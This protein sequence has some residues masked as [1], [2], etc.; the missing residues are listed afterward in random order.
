MPEARPPEARPPEPRTPEPRTLDR[1][2]ARLARAIAPS[3]PLAPLPASPRPG[4]L[5]I[6]GTGRAGTTALM[7]LFVRLGLDT[8]FTPEDVARV[9]GNV[10]RAG[11]ERVPTRETIDA[12]PDIL[13]S[14][15]LV[16]V[17]E[18]GLSEGWLEI[19]RAIVPVR[20]LGAA[21][22]SRRDVRARA[23][24]EGIDPDHAPGGLW[25]TDDPARQEEALAVAFHR[26]VEALVLHDVPTTFLAFPR[27]VRDAD[28]LAE[29][30]GPLLAAR[31]GVTDGALREA[32]VAEMRPDLVT[33][34]S[35]PRA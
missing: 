24:A 8:G 17:L 28:Y 2:R 22:Q 34:A 30:I 18:D 10:G 6:A 3:P 33:V 29:R 35:P 12:M 25:R 21:A 11:L 7:R 13:K 5:V 16:D 14:P 27:F 23:P 15:I 20:E 31:Y 32:F 26:T 4:R 1:W 19:A 9:E